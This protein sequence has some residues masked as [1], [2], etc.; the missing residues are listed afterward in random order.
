MSEPDATVFVA[1]DNPAILLGIDRALQNSGY[2]VRTAR[3]GT[4][5]LRMLQEAPR[6][7][8]LVLLD[9]MM[10]EMSGIDVLHAI[11]G[12][13]R[14]SDVPVVLITAN[15]DGDLPVSALRD[16]AVD[17]LAKPFR[18]DEL[19]ARV[20]AHVRRHRELRRAREQA[21]MRLDAIDLIRELNRVVTA[22]EMFHL[23]TTRT[24][25]IL[26][27]ARCSVV[28]LDHVARV[29]RVAASSD[30]A[31]SGEVLL[32][33]DRYPEI[34]EALET[35][36]R[37]AVSDVSTSSLFDAEREAWEASGQPA[38]LQSVVVVP[39]P[40]SASLT[41]FFVERSGPDEPVLGDEAAD[42]GERVV[43]AIIQA[44]GRVQVFQD[45]M[46]QRRRLHDMAHTDALT[47]VATRRALFLY[48]EDTLALARQRGEPL[49]IV[50]LDLDHF[51]EIN[52]TYG[53]LAGDAVLRALGEWL[54]SE[55]AL[56]SG[57]RAGRYGGDEFV[58]VLP[59][60]DMAGVMSF[61]ERARA[62]FSS[63]PF[64]FDGT[65]VQTSLSAG[66]ACWPQVEVATGE[67]LISCADAALY[68]A[69]QLGRDRV[70]LAPGGAEARV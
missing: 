64:Q 63:I 6:A 15:N 39:F 19:M 7:P 24:A 51:K 61:A 43:E 35:G 23:V 55:G 45:L 13:E 50:I 17:F 58:V 25:Q 10:P 54:C 60:A 34:R 40:I 70:S 31:S 41:G 65:T 2:A 52:D 22:D 56:R 3:N 11:R 28:V 37:V 67:D 62:R 33:L 42:L 26:G 38:P 47:G 21:R 1:D 46:E 20:G 30:A 12:E 16:G 57:D 27:V 66:I 4:E 36:G 18:L 5:V 32:D 44:C 29:A 69:K 8:D 14:L 49:G 59:G 9:V 68:Q 53:H 48:L